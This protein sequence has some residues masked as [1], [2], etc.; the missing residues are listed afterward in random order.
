M[1]L[2]VIIVGAGRQGRN[3]LDIYSQ[4]SRPVLGFLDD[5][6]ATGDLVMGVPV[7]GGTQL[8][9][10]AS[11]IA[12]GDCEWVVGIGDNIAR[13]SFQERIRAS[14]RIVS[15]AI[16]PA[17]SVAAS[18]RIGN[19]VYL[20]A[21]VRVQPEC[22]I[23]DGVLIEAGSC[24]GEGVRLGRYART[25]PNVS[26]LGGAVLEDRSFVGAGAVVDEKQTLSR[27]ARLAALSVLRGPSK[28]GCLYAGAPA[29]EKKGR[30]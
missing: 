5:E 30:S 21:F 9:D 10:D 24:V 16:H 17:A 19:G 25:G 29:T 8:I 26:L 6:H 3:L 15:T 14:G 2:P 18:A 7:L 22:E 27:D 1:P 13:E 28:P 4:T 20:G 23:S 12:H 11:R